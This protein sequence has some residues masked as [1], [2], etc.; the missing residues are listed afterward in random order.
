KAAVAV[1]KGEVMYRYCVTI[2]L[3]FI[4]GSIVSV[5]GSKSTA[6]QQADAILRSVNASDV[7][8]TVKIIGLLGK[9]MT[10]PVAIKG[11]WIFDK[12]SKAS[13]Y[14]FRVTMVAGKQL[15]EP[16]DFNQCVVSLDAVR[17]TDD[18]SAL[19]E[20]WTCVAIELGQFRNITERNW[21][22]FYDKDTKPGT[23][24]RYGDGPFVSEL[25]LAKR[26]LEREKDEKLH[27]DQ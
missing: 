11:H 4:I 6:Q 24:L 12:G 27:S 26:S 9:P 3:L 19:G 7:G 17:V 23:W 10:E 15:D 14:V 25:L 20:T 8:R 13:S 1:S 2:G 22:L 21:R 5:T 16:V 18:V